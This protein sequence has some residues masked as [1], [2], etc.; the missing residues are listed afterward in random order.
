M[1]AIADDLGIR[2]PSLYKHVADKEMLE[3]ALISDALAEI[4]EAFELAAAGSADPLASL[5][6][7]YRAWALEHPHRH[8]LTMDRPLPRE[9]LQPGLEDRAAAALV[10]AAGGDPERCPRRIRVRPRDG[11]A[12][13]QRPLPAG[14]R[15]RRSLGA[16]R[17]CVPARPP[18]LGHGASGSTEAT[19]LTRSPTTNARQR[20]PSP[21]PKAASSTS[22]PRSIGSR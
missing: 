22:S 3:V 20:R 17:R 16:R 4:A 15:P 21:K 10:A 11:R 5:A 7:A 18:R 8:R 1:R 6:A 13:A 9:R 12:R 14:R 19:A 2:A